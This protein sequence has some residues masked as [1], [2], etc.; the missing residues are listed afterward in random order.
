MLQGHDEAIWRPF[1]GVSAG[2]VFNN[3]RPLDLVSDQLPGTSIHGDVTIL[4]KIPFDYRGQH[5]EMFGEMDERMQR[6]QTSDRFGPGTSD[7]II[8]P[9]PPLCDNIRLSSDCYKYDG[10]GDDFITPVY[11][12]PISWEKTTEKWP[13]MCGDDEDCG[14]GSGDDG[15][16]DEAS[17][18]VS[19]START[20]K[21]N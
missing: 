14:E 17:I 4:D 9:T 20:C 12:Q 1:S 7:A 18:T 3:I 15:P 11:K 2:F 19:T 8:V 5:P 13:E 21:F 10:S 6:T 16:G